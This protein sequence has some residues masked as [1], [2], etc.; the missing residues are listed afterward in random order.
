MT[1][2]GHTCDESAR[3]VRGCLDGCQRS[4]RELIDRYSGLC[5][6]IAF[7]V[8]GPENC[9]YVEDAVQE[10]FFA[11]FAKLD[12]W[13]GRNLAAWIGTIAA[14]RAIDVRRRLQ[15]RQLERTGL[16]EAQIAAT[17]RGE[18]DA[19]PDLAE[20]LAMARSRL[21]R[22]QQQVFDGLLQEKSR[23]QIASELRISQRTVYYEIREIRVRL[24]DS[25]GF[26]A[27]RRPS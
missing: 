27:D 18:E 24:R 16:E 14:R 20:A 22:R 13:R 9:S 8:L 1:S 11:V 6:S 17:R 7:R 25:F 5:E 4:Q 12:Q 19:S 3:L 23:A 15:A 2:S 10:A 26:V 21:T